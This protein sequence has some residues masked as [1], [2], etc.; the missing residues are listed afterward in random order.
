MKVN[1]YRILFIKPGDA[2]GEYDNVLEPASKFPVYDSGKSYMENILEVAQR[3]QLMIIS[4]GTR[5]AYKT[6]K[7]QRFLV[8][9]V[10]LK[11]NNLFLRAVFKALWQVL[12]FIVLVCFRPKYVFCVDPGYSLLI[13]FIYSIIFHSRFFS[14]LATPV[15]SLLHTALLRKVQFLMSIKI[16]GSNHTNTILCCSHFIRN[17]LVKYGI[18]EHKLS[19][20]PFQYKKDFFK[21]KN[22]SLPIEGDVFRI[23]YAGRISNKEKRVFD[24]VEIAYRVKNIEPN[25]KFFVI[26]DGP[27]LP[28]LS[29]RIKTKR[30]NDTIY[31]LG[32][33]PSGLIYSYL[34]TADV[35][36]I[37]S[38]YEGLAKVGCEANF[39]GLPIVSSK[40]GGISDYLYDDYNGFLVEPGDMK[41]YV[42]AII[43]LYSNKSLLKKF[44]KNTK[45]ISKRLLTPSETLTDQLRKCLR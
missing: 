18:K 2:I 25:I 43:C 6:Y 12:I 15:S 4:F 38:K 22:V 23:L 42:D 34:K 36:I 28:E 30:L 39:A 9:P 33:Q 13:P 45:Q 24:L 29:T 37:T 17:E 32:Y 10:S 16:L 35:L 44:Q 8:L 19:V 31:L 11:L 1:R 20:F 5:L 3:S 14:L 41:G 21:R 27:D 7:N 40:C 26:G